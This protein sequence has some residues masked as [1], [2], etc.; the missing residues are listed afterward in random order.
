[1]L[2]GKQ[3]TAA[4]LQHAQELLQRATVRR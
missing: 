2:S 1:M 4:S 3:I